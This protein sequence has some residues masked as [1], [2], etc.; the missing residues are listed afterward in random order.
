MLETRFRFVFIIFVNIVIEIS[1]SNVV[2]VFTRIYG[3][4]KHQ[5]PGIES[6]NT[7]MR[8]RIW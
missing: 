5:D 7:Y 4:S 1:A 6:A 8:I 3:A 2:P